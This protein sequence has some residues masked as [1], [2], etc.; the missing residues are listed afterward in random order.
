EK[1]TVSVWDVPGASVSGRAG[2]DTSE[3]PAVLK[4][5]PLTTSAVCASLALVIWN[6]WLSL[7]PHVEVKLSSLADT[8]IRAGRGTKVALKLIVRTGSGQRG[9]TRLWSILPK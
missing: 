3:K 7:V 4:V 1:R 8:R 6:C 5:R 9:V 2:G